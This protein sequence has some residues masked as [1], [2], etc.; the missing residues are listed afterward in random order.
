MAP[1]DGDRLDIGGKLPQFKAFAYFVYR[2]LSAGDL[3]WIRIADVYADKLDDIQF[4]TKS[5]IHA[6]Q[7]KWS[8]QENP[9]AFSYLNFKELLFEMIKGWKN[10]ITFHANEGKFLHIHMITNRQASVNDDVLDRSGSKVGNFKDFLEHV[11]HPVKNGQPVSRRWLGILAKLHRDTGLEKKQFIDLFSALILN[12]GFVIPT[13]EGI[14]P[15]EQKKQQDLYDLTR[16][17]IE[18]IADR[19]KKIH[20]TREELIKSL[21]WEHRF[22]TTFQHEFFVDKYRYQPITS[23]IETLNAMI[24]QNSSGYIFL[25]GSPGAGK[26]TLLTQWSK[27]SL[28]HIVRYYAFSNIS[29][30]QNFSER[31]EAEKFYFDLVVQLNDLIPVTRQTILPHHDETYLRSVFFNQL[32]DLKESYQ[33]TGK[34]TIIIVDGLDHIPREYQTIKSLL[35]SLP[36]PATLP[37]GI[38]FVL[39]SQNFEIETLQ[40]DVKN[41]YRTAKRNIILDFLDRK[42]VFNY[43]EQYQPKVIM[44]IED[45][46]KVFEVSKGHPLQLTYILE[47]LSN[48]P[49]H[50]T[51]ILASDYHYENIDD[52]YQKLWESIIDVTELHDMLS[53]MARVRGEISPEFV[54]EW[55]FKENVKAEFRKKAFHLFSK[56]SHSWVF[57]HNSF[58]QFIIRK[59][60][61]DA[62]TGNYSEQYNEDFHEKLAEYYQS[63][64]SEPAWNR[65]FHLYQSKQYKI[66]LQEA[67]GAAFLSQILEYRPVE[68]VRQDMKL[69]LQIA[70]KLRDH[71]ALVR[72]LFLLSELYNREQ[73]FNPINFVEEHLKLGNREQAIRY[74]RDDHILNSSKRYA[75]SVSQD[76]YAI[77][78][79]DEAVKLYNLA[80][81]D[82]VHENGIMVNADHHYDDTSSTIEEW[83]SA[84]VLFEDIEEIVRLITNTD[85]Q[86]DK[87]HMPGNDTAEKLKARLFYYAGQTIIGQNKWDK[88]DQILIQLNGSNEYERY[89]FIMLLRSAVRSADR[90]GNDLMA[91]RYFRR[92]TSLNPDECSERERVVIAMAI[93]KRTQNREDIERWINEIPQPKLNDFDLSE[94]YDLHNYYQRFEL[95]V[96]LNIMDK[97]ISPIRAVPSTGRDYDDTMVEF[98]R[99]ICLLAAIHADGL[100]KK[101]ANNLINRIK[102]LLNF[103]YAKRSHRDTNRYKISRLRKAY[104]ELLIKTCSL[105]GDEALKE[106]KDFFLSQFGE[107]EEHWDPEQRTEVLF[108]LIGQG[109]P[110]HDLLPTIQSLEETLLE[111]ADMAG[112]VERAQT[113]AEDWLNINE[114]IRAEQ[115]MHKTIE[116]SLSI[117]YRKDYQLNTW[118][119]WLNKV[120]KIEPE[121]G[122]E[123]LQHYLERLQYVKDVTELRPFYLAAKKVLS[124]T[125]EWNF[126]AGANAQKY[127]LKNGLIHYEDSIVELVSGFLNL[128]P[129]EDLPVVNALFGDVLLDLSEEEHSKLFRGLI[130]RM[131]QARNVLDLTQ[132]LSSA[133]ARINTNA[134]EINRKFYYEELVRFSELTGFVVT[135]FDIPVNTKA[136][137]ESFEYENHLMLNDHSSLNEEDVLA[138]VNDFESLESIFNK[139]DTTNSSFRWKPIFDKVGKRLTP[140]NIRD[141]ASYLKNRRKDAATSYEL[142]KAAYNAGDHHLATELANLAIERSSSSGWNEFYDGGSRINGFRALQQTEGTV[143]IDKAFIAFLNDVLATDYPTT[144]TESIDEILPVITADINLKKVYLEV[145][146]HVKNLLANATPDLRSEGVLSLKSNDIKE[147]LFDLLHY[148]SRYPAT[149]IKYRVRRFLAQYLGYFQT[150]GIGKLADGDDTDQELLIDFLL[151]NQDDWEILEAMAEPI[152]KL[153]E[154]KSFIVKDGAR[155]LTSLISSS[156][157]EDEAPITTSLNPTYTLEIQQLGK[158]NPQKTVDEEGNIIDTDDASTLTSFVRVQSKAISKTF[159]FREINLHHRLYAIMR[160]L[161]EPFA[162]SSAN[163]KKV[164]AELESVGIKMSMVRPRVELV[165][166]A[167]S[168]MVAELNDAGFVLPSYYIPHFFFKDV[169]V[170]SFTESMRPSFLNRLKTERFSVGKEWVN[171]VRKHPRLQTAPEIT[172]SVWRVIGEYYVIKQMEWGFPEETFQSQL[173]AKNAIDGFH[174]DFIFGSVMERHVDNYLYLEG[175]PESGYLVITNEQHSPLGG[176]SSRWIAFNPKIA[177]KLCWEPSEEEPF[178]WEDEEGNLVVRSVYWRDGNVNLSQRVN[179]CETGGGWYLIASDSGLKAIAEIYQELIFEKRI[180]RIHLDDNVNRSDI[181]T[182]L[183]PF[184]LNS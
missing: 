140:D 56:S 22:K 20:Y 46:E 117:G 124:V 109:I 122:E 125:Y 170:W 142:S 85:L 105:Y 49:D 95:N 15:E 34:K 37:E 14:K 11:Y 107:Q 168:R 51:S 54:N 71:T 174:R 108:Q 31:G 24:R 76:M 93:F 18:E 69:G 47:E 84:S 66:F 147:S 172:D 179:D 99:M 86:G 130:E 134:L 156:I 154:S 133:V 137:K 155:A 91:E 62:L 157:I 138:K 17:I 143:A 81:P 100:L 72:Y 165:L 41:S 12:I 112:R 40:L 39:G 145:D 116:E 58:R 127:M 19:K 7:M 9:P 27:A 178:G 13:Q 131:W 136:A 52:Y 111:G 118:L 6:Y 135:M 173:R 79:F 4:A 123:R 150:S 87:N 2:H 128:C 77:G 175:Y 42:A 110:K 126:G 10:L 102:P 114:P 151:F 96:L 50:T 160:E 3:D 63:S 64:K 32:Q 120:N 119:D 33:K 146:S 45:K 44:T 26:S 183:T 152:S 161:A 61:I 38:I 139:E 89:L 73:N 153:R 182:H 101:G 181:A 59:T 158:L 163:E 28:D 78:L 104:F 30:S 53:L 171:D 162:W 43:I 29:I 83:A 23:T 94:T 98:E 121:F 92:F 75:L 90:A 129:L 166:Q 180:E 74:M 8:N 106:L 82:E 36:S 159:G 184:N 1:A 60:S 149:P 67:T 48:F 176:M 144:Y 164:R 55:G 57:F 148:L 70:G 113:Q 65:L 177:A 68:K 115:W 80:E 103:Y 167:M 88:L 16:F 97:G 169:A 25:S 21:N 35:G 5:E 132:E 141:L